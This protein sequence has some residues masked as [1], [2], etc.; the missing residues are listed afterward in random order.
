MTESSQ[1]RKHRYEFKHPFLSE[2]AVNLITRYEPA[3]THLGFGR[4]AAYKDRGEAMWR[5]GYGSTKVGKRF[6]RHDDRLNEIEI[7]NQLREDLENF[8]IKLEPYIQMPLNKKRS[9]AVLSY[10]FGIGLAAFKVCPLRDLINQKA[11][12]NAIIKEWSPYINPLYKDGKWLFKER[13]RAELNFYLAPDKEIPTFLPHKC[14]AEKQ[15]LLN[16]AET[17][18]QSPN[19]IKAIEYLEKKFLTWDPEGKALK[20][21]WRYWNQEPGCLGSPKNI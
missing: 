19:Q 5:I 18:N 15:C 8:A 20:R 7:L 10:A 3:R 14:R 6:V 4:F 12:K 17:W 2:E 21:F 1:Y 9:G 11:S 16:M 13:R